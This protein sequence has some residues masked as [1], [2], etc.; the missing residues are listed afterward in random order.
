MIPGSCNSNLINQ[1]GNIRKE[2]N[3]DKK[4]VYY[5]TTKTYRIIITLILSIG[6]N[7]LLLEMVPDKS[8]VWFLVIYHGYLLAWVTG[9]AL[10]GIDCSRIKRLLLMCIMEVL[11]TT[12]AI[13]NKK[14]ELM[15]TMAIFSITAIVFYLL[16]KNEKMN[17]DN[18]KFDR[19]ELDDHWFDIVD[20]IM[21]CIK[22]SFPLNIENY[23]YDRGQG[24]ITALGRMN[25]RNKYL[26]GY[27][28]L[29]TSTDGKEYLCPLRQIK[30]TEVPTDKI[31][32]GI[33]IARKDGMVEIIWHLWKDGEKEKADGIIFEL[34][35]NNK[36]NK[37]I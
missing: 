31:N 30:P 29:I 28:V 8:F 26:S 16:I 11:T 18:D 33:T 3:M 20:D 5:T 37:T 23:R 4:P 14:A 10:E 34:E 22:V 1:G 36:E 27:G 19:S 12:I 9:Y 2:Q 32:T 7:V 6:I 25:R 35:E 21:Y 13:L 15:A 24:Y 17:G